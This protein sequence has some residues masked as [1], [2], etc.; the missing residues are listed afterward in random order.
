[1][2]DPSTPAASAGT[3]IM[4]SGSHSSHTMS[5]V[6]I[7]VV[8][9]I[10]RWTSALRLYSTVRVTGSMATHAEVAPLASAK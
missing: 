5:A 7:F 6:I 9:A 10:G 3:E 8:L 1:M 2:L 4:R